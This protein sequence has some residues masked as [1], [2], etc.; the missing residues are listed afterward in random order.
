MQPSENHS[1]KIKRVY[2]LPD[3]HDGRRILVDRLWPRG[4]TKEKAGID[5]WLKEIA[6][7]TE[8]RKWFDHDPGRWE[9][10]KDQYLAELKDNRE[11]IRLL[12]QE[13]DKGIVTLVYAAK[14]EEHNQA[15][16]IQENDWLFR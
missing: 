3:Q 2:E 5:L 16:V 11:Q 1:I 4:L 6:P 9:E 14:D 8:L 10:F 13:L 15:I 12:K 7:S